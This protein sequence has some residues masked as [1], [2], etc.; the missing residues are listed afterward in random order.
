[1]SLGSAAP[2]RRPRCERP[3][4]AVALAL[5]LAPADGAWLT[6]GPLPGSPATAAAAA[7][8]SRAA[9]VTSVLADR[10]PAKP[11]AGVSW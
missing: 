6:G 4:L 1:M 3:L 8:T 10:P 2:R 7:A 5:S 9:A 11:A